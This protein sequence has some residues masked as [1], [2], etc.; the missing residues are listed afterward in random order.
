LGEVNLLSLPTVGSDQGNIPD[1]YDEVVAERAHTPDA[2][3]AAREAWACL[4]DLWFGEASHDRFHEACEAIDVSPPQLKAL[5]S[6]QADEPLAMRDIAELLRCDASWVT[7][8]VDG[9]EEHGYV[10]RRPHERDRRVKTVRITPTGEKARERA[11]EQLHQ[12]PDV[13]LERL[14]DSDLRSLR[15]VLRKLADPADGG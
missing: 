2:E 14:T 5:L 10:E 4:A 7:E 8:L 15:R 11:R 3:A 9:L 13:L 6:L 1:G 12:P